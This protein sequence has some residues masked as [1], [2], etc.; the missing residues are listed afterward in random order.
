MA[1]W[2]KDPKTSP[3]EGLFDPTK[4]D[5]V[6]LSPDG[7]VVEIVIVNDSP[8]TGSDAQ[9]SSLQ[10]KIQTCVGFALDGQMVATYP[11]TEGSPW[12]IVIADQAGAPDTRSADVI[13]R[14][15]ERVRQY[16]G[17]LLVR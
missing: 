10:Q 1:L 2:K 14:I 9:V 17:D 12:R 3:P 13:A 8:W 16:G 4:V 6:A 11:E 15:A 5:L 7:E